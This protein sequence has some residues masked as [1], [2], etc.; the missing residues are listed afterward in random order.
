M[1]QGLGHQLHGMVETHL[2][3][4]LFLFLSFYLFS[5]PLSFSLLT[6][7]LHYNIAVEAAVSSRPLML[8][9]DNRSR[10]CCRSTT[11]QDP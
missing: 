4:H 10:P 11:H 6:L 5:L 7:L 8:R 9:D 2:L 3:F 1:Y